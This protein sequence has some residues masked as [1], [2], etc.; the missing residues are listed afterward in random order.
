MY[1]YVTVLQI[2]CLLHIQILINLYVTSYFSLFVYLSRDTIFFSEITSIY[3]NS[4]TSTF[5]KLLVFLMYLCHVSVTY[6]N[7]FLNIEGN[8]SFDSYYFSNTLFLMN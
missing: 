5:K 4:A 1:V 8:Y 2:L 3:L 7:F 6:K